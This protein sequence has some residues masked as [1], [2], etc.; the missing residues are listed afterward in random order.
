MVLRRDF[1]V[2]SRSSESRFRQVGQNPVFEQ[3]SSTVRFDLWVVTHN[4]RFKGCRR[5]K[6]HAS[7]AGLFRSARVP[8]FG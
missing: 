8:D 2:V 3:Y 4:P 7:P 6:R 5:R 1:D